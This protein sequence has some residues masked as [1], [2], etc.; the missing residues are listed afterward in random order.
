M[1]YL[2]SILSLF[3][4]TAQAGDYSET[5]FKDIVGKTL[6][7]YFDR[8][9][10]RSNLTLDLSMLSKKTY[11]AS[12]PIKIRFDKYV[13]N[14]LIGK[15]YDITIQD[16]SL[17]KATIYSSNL[18]DDRGAYKYL[19]YTES[20]PD[21]MTLNSACVSNIDPNVRIAMNQAARQAAQDKL[22]VERR[23]S[24]I[25]YQ[26]KALKH[27]QEKAIIDAEN[28]RK[29]EE[30]KRKE[31]EEREETLKSLP[32]ELK[33]YTTES[34]CLL[35]GKHRPEVNHFDRTDYRARKAIV[36]ELNARKVKF[37]INAEAKTRI[38]MSECDMLVKFGEPEKRNT[39]VGR[40]GVHTQ[41]VYKNMN[42]YTENGVVTSVQYS[43]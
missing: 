41:N 21:L 16:E 6:W 25:A 29:E 9:E 30:I 33:L 15:Y 3:M 8:D 38:G 10:C 12:E 18:N 17:T 42:I 37:N 24:Q 11:E 34:I 19:Y 32:D 5:Q 7:V 27:A 35:Y 28:K 22:E 40:W 23:E 26:E 31:F 36:N 1:K 14:W 4:L 43:Q 20:E 39:S 13:D 2:S